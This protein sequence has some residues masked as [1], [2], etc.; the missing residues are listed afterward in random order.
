MTC[1]ASDHHVLWVPDVFLWRKG[2]VIKVTLGLYSGRPVSLIV[3]ER[4]C[5]TRRVAGTPC[6]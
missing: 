2:E 3:S 5:R 1:R 4:L 6:C